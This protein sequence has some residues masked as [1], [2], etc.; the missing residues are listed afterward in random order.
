MRLERKKASRRSGRGYLDGQMLI[1]MPT[2]QDERFFRTR[3]LPQLKHLFLLGRGSNGGRLGKAPRR[4]D[5]HP[6]VDRPALGA[7]V[8]VPWMASAPVAS[9]PDVFELC[10]ANRAEPAL[11]KL[12]LLI[13]RRLDGL[14]QGAV[15]VG[16][17]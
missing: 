17:A 11:A 1:A 13:T 16:E 10:R 12:Q 5:G 14:L 4:L 9:G 7:A 3:C 8:G 15:G 2:T 6:G